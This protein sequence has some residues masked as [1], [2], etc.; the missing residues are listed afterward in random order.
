[1]KVSPYENTIE[2]KKEPLKRDPN[3]KRENYS[4]VKTKNIKWDI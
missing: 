4:S 2:N 1:M 3:I